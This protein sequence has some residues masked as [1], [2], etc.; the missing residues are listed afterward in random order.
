MTLAVDNQTATMPGRL[1]D[2][3]PDSS[4]LATSDDR[5]V[6]IWD[7]ATGRERAALTGFKDK[8][9]VT[10]I[11]GDSSLLA[12]VCRTRDDSDSDWTVQVWDPD[13]GSPQALMRVE[14]TILTCA[15]IG[16]RALALGGV[17]GLYVFDYIT[18][19]VMSAQIPR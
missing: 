12:T 16:T 15:W 17:A 19:D 3:A 4:W 18:P 6:R 7:T 13:T 9:T 2:I 14:N 8:V 5:A 1:L 11:T 10:A